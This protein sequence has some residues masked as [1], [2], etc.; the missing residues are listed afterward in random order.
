MKTYF[1]THLVY[2][3][4]SVKSMV[5][6][7]GKKTIIFTSGQSIYFKSESRLGFKEGKGFT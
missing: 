6:Y 7:D 5:T 2:Q 3:N 4:S 1:R